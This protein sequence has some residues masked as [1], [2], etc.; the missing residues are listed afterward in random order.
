MVVAL[1]QINPVIGDL[2]GNV[3]LMHERIDEARE[4]GAQLVLFPEL[5]VCG[6]PPEDLL[7]R[8]D[9]LSACA[10][11]AEEV[12]AAAHDL[13]VAF[14][15]PLNGPRDLHNTLVVAAEGEIRV[16]YEK[17]HLPHYGTFDE[18]RYFGRGSGP[19]VVR[20]GDRL[21]G[22]CVC[23]DL[24]IGDGPATAAVRA[25]AELILNA[26]ASPFQA[27]KARDREAMLSHR[28]RELVC[29]IAYANCWGGHDE[30]VFDGGSTVV[31]H[32]GGVLARA[33]SFAEELLLVPLDLRPVRAARLRDPRL[34]AAD[35]TTA[36]S[37]GDPAAEPRITLPL[38]A[39]QVGPPPVAHVLEH[40]AELWLAL[41]LGIADHAVKNGLDHAVVGLG[42]GIDSSLVAVL[43]CEA[44]GPERVTAVLMPA[45]DS[46]RRAED[47]ARELAVALGCELRE[48]PVAGL[49][50]AYEHA[51][52]PAALSSGAGS[53]STEERVLARIRSNVLMALA[54]L[55]GRLLLSTGNKS[56]LACG[57][58][59]LYG[60]TFGGFAPLKDV[61]RTTV[62]RLAR[63]RQGNAPAPI[64][65]AI[66]RDPHGGVRPSTWRQDGL[67]PFDVVDP[68]L[69]AYVEDDEDPEALVARGHDPGVVRRVVDLVERAEPKRRQA[70]PGIRIS[71]RAFGQDRRMP[72]AHR[73]R[74]TG[75]TYDEVRE[76]SA[77]AASS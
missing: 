19:V 23:A 30:L 1:A 24:W 41:R 13:V 34:R 58:A 39:S 47:A 53:W 73:F 2:P 16:V 57:Y 25:G 74:A 49:L 68:I 43:A 77:G 9:F 66:L 50:D 14:G 52:G 72:L 51:L 37:G 20:I 64:P 31:D 62:V 70:P 71:A 8:S 75:D 42:G 59:T 26:S 18:G 4:A 69:Q 36:T 44:L 7:L 63:W 35:E 22:L 48:V 54:N 10:A 3:G 29:P 38:V 21:V 56:E 67:P 27:G 55:P 61:P 12:A 76:R 32:R 5:A 45:A 28:A 60:E 65:V 40:D 46:D 15:V 33:E 6:Y 17:R 11:A